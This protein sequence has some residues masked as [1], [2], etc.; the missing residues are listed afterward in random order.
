MELDA[1]LAVEV[2]VRRLGAGTAEVAA[3]ERAR[4]L[5]SRIEGEAPDGCPSGA[6]IRR[7]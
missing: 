7:A 2:L 4:R 5:L 1:V 3:V 6:A